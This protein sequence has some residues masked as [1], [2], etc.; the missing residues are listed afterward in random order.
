MTT[1]E[2][3]TKPK[4]KS[5]S[6]KV[7][8]IFDASPKTLWSHWTDPEKFAKW[9]NP[10]PGMD[11]VVHEY[12]VRVGG[13][14]RFDMPQPDGNKNPQE[15]V[16]HVLQPYREIVS[17]AADKSFLVATTFAK[18]GKRTRMTVT[19]TGVPPEFHDG[20]RKGWNAGFNK[21]VDVIEEEATAPRAIAATRVF[22]APRDVVWRMWTHPDQIAQWWGPTGF[23]NSIDSMDV[24]R[25]GRWTFVMHG[26][27]G[28]DY[29]NEM[30]YTEVVEPARI[31]YDHITGPK[32]HTTVLFTDLGEKT[33]ISMRM[34]F[35]TKALRDRTAKEYGAVEGLHETLGR[36]AEHLTQA[37][38]SGRRE[39]VL[40]RVLKAP[41]RQVWEAWTD[42]EQVKGWWGPKGFTAPHVRIDVRAGGTYVLCM[43]GPGLDG[44]LRDNWN[45]GE[46]REILR[47]EKIVASMRFADEHGQVVPASYYGL[48]GDWPRRSSSP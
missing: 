28:R 12:D 33:K 35:A 39:V 47:E 6:L 45:V 5:P 36:L 10:A 1:K 26:P 8:R 7:E 23:T 46:F 41:R 44:I 22:D 48:P 14:V 31:A 11:L 18:V 4:A 29:D 30:W 13:R 25:G 24:R 16:F 37:S 20:A 15:G 34:V 19:V 3:A 38:T 43:R 40:T 32:F 2:S 27:D 9:F 42:S 17:G 21:L